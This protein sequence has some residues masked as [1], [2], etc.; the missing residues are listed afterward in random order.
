MTN[1]RRSTFK[2][3]FVSTMLVVIFS[4][5]VVSANNLECPSRRVFDVG[6]HI[7]DVT[8]TNG[9]Y[10]A[11]TNEG[12]VL[13]SGDGFEW[14]IRKIN[15]SPRLIRGISAAEEVVIAIDAFGKIYRS[16]DG[17]SWEV[18]LNDS[19][20]KL[21]TV[22]SNGKE[23][24]VYAREAQH[25]GMLL[26]SEHNGG[27]WE[28]HYISDADP[29]DWYYLSV[30]GSQYFVSTSKLYESGDGVLWNRIV[31]DDLN[32]P[33]LFA[34]NDDNLYVNTAG[35]DEVRIS[36]NRRTWTKVLIKGNPV[37]VNDIKWVRNQFII[38][39]NC[40]L[41]LTSNDGTDWLRRTSD[42][43]YPNR[44]N[45]VASNGETIVIAGEATKA[46]SDGVSAVVLVSR[47][48]KVWDN[49]SEKIRTVL[50]DYKSRE[51]SQE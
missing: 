23:F 51:T 27:T 49:I 13:I 47:D 4:Y 2:Y 36:Q 9:K 46:D 3:V 31:T 16:I 29:L 28:R 17:E 32:L 39:G 21:A 10:V 45:A 5:G 24:V 38:V 6:E 20:L 30:V 50:T 26:Y 34:K 12:H 14:N 40:S 22:E 8:H 42:L 48:G 44:L 18:V 33:G 25:G 1:R 41:I 19:S 11:V 37:P 15:Q 35:T 7:E 43:Q